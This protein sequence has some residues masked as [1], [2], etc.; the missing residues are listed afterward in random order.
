MYTPYVYITQF[1]QLQPSSDA[2]GAGKRKSNRRTLERHS[3]KVAR[4]SSPQLR[5]IHIHQLVRI[6]YTCV[7]FDTVNVD[8][9][10]C[11]NVCR[12]SRN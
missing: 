7:E 1:L 4:S 10:M 3:G 9:W 2:G 5:F 8:W 6:Q 11:I 12:V